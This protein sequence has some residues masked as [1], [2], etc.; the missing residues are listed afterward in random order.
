MIIKFGMGQ[1]ME[2]SNYTIPDDK[3]IEIVTP[4]I[5]MYQWEFD[6][7][8]TREQMSYIM[9]QLIQSYIV[10]SRDEKLKIILND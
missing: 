8:K 6:T 9:N 5:E 1:E 10:S 2:I 7:K 3:I 4:V